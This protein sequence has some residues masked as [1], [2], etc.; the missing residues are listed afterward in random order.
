MGTA[1]FLSRSNERNIL[2]T[3]TI[4]GTPHYMAPEIVK[5]KG[6]SFPVDYWSI[7]I[8]LYE[9]MCGMLPFG[10]DTEDPY[11]IYEEILKK[12]IKYPSYLKDKKARR[13]MNQL[14]SEVPE[15]R[16]NGSFG[17]IKADPW[18]GDFDWVWLRKIIEKLVVF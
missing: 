13:L 4:I 18:F 15:V 16:V 7:G 6:Y 8:C 3:F 17:S 11:E 14:L 12:E 1:K 2:K 10:E 5:S 9:F